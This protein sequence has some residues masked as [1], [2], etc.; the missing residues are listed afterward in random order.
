MSPTDS[1]HDNREYRDANAPSDIA[2]LTYELI[3]LSWF[4]FFDCAIVWLVMHNPLSR[5]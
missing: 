4:N 2:M 3:Y 5:G 1:G